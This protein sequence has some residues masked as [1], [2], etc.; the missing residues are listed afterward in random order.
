MKKTG[1]KFTAIIVSL[2]VVAG[3]TIGAFAAEKAGVTNEYISYAEEKEDAYAE[4]T[5]EEAVSENTVA[6]PDED[7]SNDE[8]VY[9]FTDSNGSVEKVM[10]SI[11]IKDGEDKTQTEADADLP[12]TVSVKYSLDGKEIAP[13]ALTGKSG[14]LKAEVSFANNR[15][16]YKEINGNEEKIYVPFLA[17]AVTALD[18]EKYSNV[19]VS[20]GRVI[21][22]GARYAVVGVALPGLKEDLDI[23]A[24]EVE[25]PES[26]TIEAD[27]ENFEE[28]CM[29]LLVTNSVFNEIDIDTTEKMDELR[30]D[31]GK[32]DDAM[33]ALMN[34]SDELYN[35]LG[36]LLDGAN[37]FNDGMNQLSGGLNTLDSN[38]AAL[39][40]G[41]R[42]VFNTLLATASEQLKASGINV[43]NL[44]IDNY[45]SVLASVVS[46][47][48]AKKL[49]YS[50]VEAKVKENEGTIRNAVT[51]AVNAQVESG[52]E[53]AVRAG[54]EEK[55]TAAVKTNVEAQVTAAVESNVKNQVA[56]AVAGQ[57]G[58]S[59]E[60]ALASSE[61][62]A[63][64]D[65]TVA[66]K[67]AS[68]EVK[69]MITAQTDAQMASDDVKATINAKV[70]EQMATPEVQALIESTK[71][72]KL[73]SDE[74]KGIIDAKTQET[75]NSKISE[76]ENSPEVQAQ[77]SAG[78]KK[79]LDL[80]ASLDSYNT[81]Y[82]GVIAYTNGVSKANA[83][84]KELNKN[85]PELVKGIQALK[86]GEKKLSDGLTQFNDEGVVK[87]NDLVN[88][89]LEGMVERFNTVKEVS[90]DYASYG[91][92][93]K[94][95]KD[96]VRFIYK[97]KTV[98]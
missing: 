81:Y 88:N 6:A 35:G 83:G 8:V 42:Q 10:D 41:S 89:T 51:D 3:S 86:D 38:S 82:Q 87:L 29:Y 75:I 97:I 45:D 11:W 98:K 26:I 19:T 52:V 43:G 46:E 85:M 5:V 21:N 73:S 44:T 96:G 79:I 1:K 37:K 20:N 56:D 95:T 12:L 17:S 2:A 94:D 50:T 18:G 40:D 91:T 76:Y 22:D 4:T 61:A 64:I 58:I 67:M 62:S 16:E 49:A 34:G 71:A 36:K 53:D 28:F 74:V 57:L 92:D 30:E 27:V 77:I 66:A 54:V 78:D 72:S 90:R 31:L 55:V 80:K 60:D 24:N 48:Y 70:E 59:V 69:A 14:H 7:V 47:G 65:Q 32:I 33:E 13:D 15:Y 68:D 93:G 25:I 63:M 39:V 84:A 23:S 9:V